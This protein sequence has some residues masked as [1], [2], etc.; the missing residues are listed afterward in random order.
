MERP[1]VKHLQAL[2]RIHRY[3]KGTL[4]YGLTYTKG[5]SKV[6]LTGYS[7]SDFGKDMNDGKSTGGTT[8]YMNDNLV[9]WVSQKQCSVAL[10]SCEAEFMAATMAACQGVWLRRLLTK[11][12]GKNMPHVALFIDNRSVLELMNNPM[13]H[14]R[15][16]HIDIKYHFIREC[17]ENGEIIVSHVCG[18][19]QKADI[20]TKTMA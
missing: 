8:F 15:S 14:G 6:T 19:K 18:M 16:K 12:T 20:Y 7:D 10:S 13:F 3:I 9:T 17:V 11:I 1:T 4:N 2:K 5:E